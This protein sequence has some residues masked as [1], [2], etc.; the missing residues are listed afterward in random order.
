[1][2]RQLA[3]PAAL[4]G[5]RRGEAADEIELIDAEG[6]VVILVA[7]GINAPERARVREAAMQLLGGPSPTPSEERRIPRDH[8]IPG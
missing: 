8:Q 2:S 1:M 7:Y 6:N 5:I 3:A 4:R